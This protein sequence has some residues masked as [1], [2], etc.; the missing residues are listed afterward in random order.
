MNTSG[1]I[2]PRAFSVRAAH[3][4]SEGRSG[5]VQYS[6]QDWTGQN[7]G[8]GGQTLA[9]AGYNGEKVVLL[10]PTDQTFYDAMCQVIGARMKAR[11]RC[12]YKTS[13]DVRFR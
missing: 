4:F 2:Q 11:S 1:A 13:P 12:F 3:Q 10:H 5:Y 6:Y 7:Q 8:V 9:A